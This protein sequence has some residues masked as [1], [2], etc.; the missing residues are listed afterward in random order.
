MGGQVCAR[1]CMRNIEGGTSMDTYACAM[2]QVDGYV[3]RHNVRRLNTLEVGAGRMDGRGYRQ[4][5]RRSH[6][7]WNGH[8]DGHGRGVMSV[9]AL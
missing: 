4:V 3:D 8:S 6:G 1:R 9:L 7:H 2:W 5:A